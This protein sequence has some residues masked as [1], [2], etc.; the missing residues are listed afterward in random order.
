MLTWST[1]KKEKRNRGIRNSENK[2]EK[3]NKMKDL[4]PSMSITSLNVNCLCKPIKRQR[5]SQWINQHDP[6]IF[7]RQETP[8]VE[9]NKREKI[10]H[11]NSYPKEGQ[12]WLH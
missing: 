7:C 8:W 12:K 2:P 4:G 9:W 10:Y 1:E 11:A 5:L 3:N 6:T